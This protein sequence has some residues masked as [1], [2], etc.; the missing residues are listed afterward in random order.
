MKIPS[1][2]KLLFLIPVVAACTSRS[3][4]DGESKLFYFIS[5]KP[6]S[7]GF[8]SDRLARLDT[9]LQQ[10][11]DRGDLP[12][13]VTFI[14]RKGKVIHYKA[15]GFRNIEK[16]I[17]LKTSDIFRIASQSKA[18]TT[19]ALM[20]LYEEGKF[21]LDEPVS[22][23]IPAFKNPRVIESF[24]PADSSYVA[25]PAQSEIS[26]RQLLN[27]TAGYPYDHPVYMKAGIPMLNSTENITIEEIVNKLA[28]LPLVHDPGEAF[29]Y[30]LHTDIVGH[31]VE[32]ISGKPLD[33]FIR[34]RI[35]DP[36]GMK[37]SYFYLPDDK[38]DRLV[39][40]YEKPTMESKLVVSAHKTNQDFPVAGYKRYFS[41]GAGLVGTIEDYG[42]FCLMLLN[43]GE[44]NGHRILGKK[45]IGM[46]TTNQIGD[47][48]LWDSFN[49]FGLGFEITTEKGVAIIPGSIG[50][51]KWGGI[52]STD[53]LIDPKEDMVC[54]VYTNVLPNAFWQFT[55]LYR[56]IVY[57][58]MVE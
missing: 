2:I 31:L 56:P 22:R 7:V 3:T 53:Y 21:G 35:F 36:L 23:Y 54:L 30:G 10:A 49:K 48:N 42:R 6:E 12:N 50:S 16:K 26:I 40:L 5:A 9:F 4:H 15:Y 18:V 11:V 58:A 28:A 27:H 14:A 44:F 37:D 52:Y 41:G 51:F 57:Q 13:A 19:V 33:V 34:E 17:P 55:Q 45:T 47:L 39:T 32:V 20:T 25:R 38:M 24:N 46:M 1:F 29:T 8:S 43:G